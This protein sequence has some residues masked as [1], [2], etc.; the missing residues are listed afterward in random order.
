MS[1]QTITSSLRGSRPRTAITV[2][3]IVILHQAA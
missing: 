2:N 1:F 3:Y